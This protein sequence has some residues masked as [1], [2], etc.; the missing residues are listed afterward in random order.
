MFLALRE[1]RFARGR[2]AL[3]GVVI[4][5]ISLLVVLLSGLSSGLVNDGVSGLKSMPASAFAFDGGTKADNAFS[6][7]VVDEDQ[8]VAWDGADGI[9]EAEPM[10]VNIVNGVTDD[11]TQI[12]LTLF[13]VQTD[14]FLAPPVSSGE[15]IGVANGIVVSEPMKDSGVEIG[16]VVT[17]ER[18]DV[19]LTVV[20]FT[21]GQATFGHVDVAYLPLDTWKLM[22][23]GA[24]VPGAPTDAQ[25]AAVD[26]PYASV[27][28]LQAED[29]VTPDYEAID[30]TA[31]TTTMTL[32]EAFNA[33]P[34]YEAETL[35]LSM[36][37]FFLYAISALVVG[38][39]FT[40][41]TI[42]RSHDLAVLRAVGASSRYLLRDSLMQ[43][44][45]LL[46]GFT[47]LGVAAGVGLGALMPDAMPFALEAAPI[48]VA[49]GLTIA[50]GLIG[51]AV[52]VLRIVRIDPLRALGGQR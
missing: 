18:V 1:L 40:V 41:W 46:V 9:A 22:A 34:G 32:T 15:G 23:A 26:F 43:A 49:S 8:L 42:Q 35:T 12:D 13:G 44:A 17:L 4:A 11:G 7:S 14:G 47:A 10:G 33:S 24:A 5:L 29:G 2:F 19:E 38:A 31:D 3:M 45:I 39:F 37:Q 20:G 51:A 50:L 21:E 52:A 16:T 36:I 6:R 30:A 27:V 28:A 25:L 48:A